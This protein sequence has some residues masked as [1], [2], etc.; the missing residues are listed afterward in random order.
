MEH[1]CG[2]VAVV[3][4]AGSGIGAAVTCRLLQ[5]GVTVVG[6][7]LNLN[8]LQELAKRHNSPGKEVMKFCIV[9]LIYM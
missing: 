9:S 7:D 1:W 8:G 3:T 5:E 4:G 6:I 2:R